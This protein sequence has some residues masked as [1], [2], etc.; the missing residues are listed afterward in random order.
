MD[1]DSNPDQGITD[2]DSNPDESSF[3]QVDSNPNEVIDVESNVEN[4][5]C[6]ARE[7]TPPIIVKNEQEAYDLYN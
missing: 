7:K 2:E 3:L 1:G 6:N 5:Q 4:I